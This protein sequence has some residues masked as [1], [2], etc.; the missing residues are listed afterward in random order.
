MIIA[1]FI[2]LTLHIRG[3]RLSWVKRSDLS[4]VPQQA[5][6]KEEI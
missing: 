5:N 1:G 2:L 3:Q 6:G 4:D